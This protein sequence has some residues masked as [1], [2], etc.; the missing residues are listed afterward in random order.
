MSRK[1]L[2][3]WL[4]T[5]SLTGFN[6][7][8]I[9]QLYEQYATDPNSVDDNWAQLFHNLEESSQITKSKYYASSVGNENI[10]CAN[11][12]ETY[13]NYG[14]LIANID[15]LN[16]WK[17]NE[18]TP[19]NLI[20]FNLHPDQEV[21]LLTPFSG[22][23]KYK[24]SDLYIK[25]RYLYTS[26]IGYELNHISNLAVKEWLCKAIELS[27]N[28]SAYVDKIRRLNRLVKAEQFEII[29][30]NK[31]PGAK[32]FSLE[33]TESL[34]TL[35]DSL[36]N[37]SADNNLR[38][39]VLGM[40]HRGRLNV[41]VNQLG[42]PMQEIYDLFAGKHTL[43]D[44]FSG[45]V[46]Y[47]YGRSA[48]FVKT[49]K[50]SESLSNLTDNK[51][52]NY[53]NAHL[54]FNP[55]HLEFVSAIAMGAARAKATE[56]NLAEEENSNSVDFDVANSKG[57][58]YVL[59]I[60][61]HGDSAVS[62]QGIVQE[63]LNMSNTRGYSVGGGIHIVLNNQIG[64]TTNNL[65]DMRSSTYASDIA[66]MIDAPIFH[67]NAEDL[68]AVAKAANLAFQY[69][70]RYKKDVFIDL[71]GY[72]RQG[73][74]EAEDPTITQP[75]LYQLIK[76][77]K[78]ISTIYSRNLIQEGIIEEQYLD[79]IRKKYYRE[80]NLAT[81]DLSIGNLQWE[82]EIDFQEKFIKS[83]TLTNEEDYKLADY[84]KLSSRELKDLAMQLVNLPENYQ[85]AN[86]L[87]KLYNQRLEALVEDKKL[88]W[89]Q[90]E[91]LAF[92][93]LLQ[94]GVNIRLTG[95]D[96]GRGTF[97]HR[98]S[99]IRGANKAQEYIP[100]SEF[101]KDNNVKFEVWDSTLSESGVLGFEY[102]ASI[103][104][105]ETL[106]LWEA[107]F[108][109]FANGAQPIID[110]FIASG[111]TKWGQVSGLTMLLPHGYE[112]Q[113]PEHSSGRI[114]RF[115][116]LCADNNLRV[117]VP[118]EAKNMYHLLVNQGLAK[119]KKPLVVF[120]PKSL[121]RHEQASAT[122]SEIA[123]SSF[124]EAVYDV[125]K[126]SD[127]VTKVVITS[128]KIRFDVSDRLK[129]LNSEEIFHLHLE[130]LYP[131]PAKSISKILSKC[132][133]LKLIEVVQDEPQNQGYWNYILPSLLKLLGDKLGKVHIGYNGRKASASTATGYQS[134][135]KEE[136]DKILSN[137]NNLDNYFI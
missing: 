112:G 85:V 38:D 16:I 87:Q 131:L 19:F 128:G 17:R 77:K 135:H 95:E 114:E 2:E 111:E 92:A 62:G 123:S 127:K 51:P 76:E 24:V 109:D 10:N 61:I 60:Y 15:P 69:R 117:V 58:D 56:Y 59:P 44:S 34:M 134:V 91:Q 21:T 102:G 100:L 124:A 71:I 3:E 104:S 22:Q 6:Q 43:D 107:Q 12:I 42:M 35:L 55:S 115:L 126:L 63:I 83:P 78:L 130:Q 93:T 8:Y 28:E 89:G 54:M 66:K 68:D 29:L 72:R 11:L 25:L 50:G 4:S 122:I 125:N 41:L 129:E 79:D 23:K 7:L 103:V 26:T 97:F 57:T 101:A 53:L 137:L 98:A 94:Q 32:R 120:T 5:T 52:V 27:N 30:N 65:K 74:N 48:R 40:A 9:E 113:G 70:Q 75:D 105:P 86:T 67:V 81:E 36:F 18:S 49:G 90:V 20:D 133:N 119:Y 1:S 121:L 132:P 136:L 88:Q 45:D 96:A 99:V 46:K 37:L 14:H 47:H 118:T 84:E 80:F 31:Y 110:Q 106:V 116:Q 73:H 39:V 13:R 82:K 64:F 108:G 33:G